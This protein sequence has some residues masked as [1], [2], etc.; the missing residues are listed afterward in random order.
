MHRNKSFSPILDRVHPLRAGFRLP[1]RSG[2]SCKDLVLQP[3]SA[4]NEMAD[5]LA[6][7]LNPRG[8]R[9]KSRRQEAMRFT[10]S[11]RL[12]LAMERWQILFDAPKYGPGTSCTGRTSNSTSFCAHVLTERRSDCLRKG[13]RAKGLLHKGVKIEFIVDIYNFYIY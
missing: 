12:C 6:F 13:R 3:S 10:P 7:R 9:S 1:N 2:A 11:L 4:M 5:S 8:L